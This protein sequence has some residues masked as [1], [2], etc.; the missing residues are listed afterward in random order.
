MP[1]RPPQDDDN[2]GREGSPFTRKGSGMVK[3]FISR[4]PRHSRVTPPISEDAMS[5]VH[6]AGISMEQVKQN[7]METNH[8]DFK[9]ANLH[10]H[11]TVPQSPEKVSPDN[12]LLERVASELYH[13]QD[14]LLPV[15]ITEVRHPSTSTEEGEEEDEDVMVENRASC[16]VRP[17]PSSAPSHHRTPLHSQDSY[18][19]LLTILETP[20]DSEQIISPPAHFRPKLDTV[21][22]HSESVPN[23]PKSHGFLTI[24]R[25]MKNP[26]L[27]RDQHFNDFSRMSESYGYEGPPSP[28]LQDRFSLLPPAEERERGPPGVKGERERRRREAVSRKF[29]RKTAI[30]RQRRK[31]GGSISELPPDTS[32][33]YRVSQTPTHTACC[34]QYDCS[35]E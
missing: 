29:K 30:R 23:K 10:G 17:A 35:T 21:A 14:S 11:R 3:E 33:G 34:T 25:R 4:T 5:P 2:G 19:E 6:S 24:Q 1:H 12:R 32:Y 16:G 31:V 28:Q 9:H 26:L 8:A 20:S 15:A 27:S 13:C 18:E 7:G 22:H